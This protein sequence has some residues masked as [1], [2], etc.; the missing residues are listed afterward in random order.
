MIVLY[1]TFIHNETHSQSFA[2]FS[3]AHSVKRI[4]YNKFIE[5]YAT[6]DSSAYTITQHAQLGKQKELKR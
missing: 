2:L 1:M 3:H 4:V 6:Y 5:H